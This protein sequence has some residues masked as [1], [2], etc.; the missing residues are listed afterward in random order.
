MARKRWCAS[1]ISRGR[2]LRPG[3]D[4]LLA[5]IYFVICVKDPWRENEVFSN[6]YRPQLITNTVLSTIATRLEGE[7]LKKT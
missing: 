4:L 7:H 3:F 2:K 1:Q 6:I 5:P